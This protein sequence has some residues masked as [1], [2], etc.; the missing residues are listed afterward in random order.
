MLLPDTIKRH[1][2]NGGYV[3]KYAINDS[4]NF[5]HVVY[6]TQDH[7][8]EPF[9]AETY[10]LHATSWTQSEWVSVSHTHTYMGTKYSSIKLKP[11]RQL[12]TPGEPLDLGEA[13]L[14]FMRISDL[15]GDYLPPS[16]YY[17]ADDLEES[18]PVDKS[19]PPFIMHMSNKD[20]SLLAFRVA[21]SLGRDIRYCP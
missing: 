9:Y 17:F 6:R 7:H 1:I 4:K 11:N 18:P 2:A 15:A 5:M 20:S 14:E 8:N 12:G 13:D 10:A 16:E 19:K 3:L 21:H